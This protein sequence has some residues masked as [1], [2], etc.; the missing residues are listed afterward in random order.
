M[1]VPAHQ[2]NEILIAHIVVDSGTITVAGSSWTALPSAPTNP[3]T[4]GIVSYL[5]YVKAAGSTETLTLTTGDAYTCGIYCY[6]DVDGTTPFDGVT[7]LHAGVASA[8][9]TPVNSTISTTTA[10]DLVVYHIAQNGTTPQVLSDPGVMSIYNADSTGTTA[11]TSSHQSAA[12]YIQRTAGTT[13]AANWSSS[14][15]DAYNRTLP[16]KRPGGAIPPIST[17]HHPWHS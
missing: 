8:T 5:L 15:S 7:P 17:T 14:I 10:N 6:R 9:T 1:N 2:T 13:P 12:W 4:Q 3:I 16:S 11:T